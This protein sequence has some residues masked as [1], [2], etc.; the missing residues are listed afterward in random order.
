M[1]KA[2]ST[3]LLAAIAATALSA[4]SS[5]RN[6]GPPLQVINRALATA[7]GAAQPSTIVAREI[8]FARA[9]RE[10]GQITA[11]KRFA[12]PGAKVHRE[13]GIR[14]GLSFLGSEKNPETSDAWGTAAVV[15][16]C[17]G[18]LAVTQGRFRDSQGIVGDYVTVWKRQSDGTYLWQYDVSGPDVPQPPPRREFEDGEIVVIAI[19]S[20]RGLVASCPG[21]GEAIPSPP[22][23][24]IGEDGKAEAWLSRDGT[25]RWRWEHREDGAKYVAA[26]YYYNGEWVTAIEESLAPRP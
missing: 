22:A 8:E 12:A 15:M 18:R 5:G 3:L 9:A 16:S 11:A 4:C 23:I 10:E 7:P 19:P 6:R 26:D 21:R 20:I 13:G 25:L 1:M 14:D 24:P 2:R 17:D